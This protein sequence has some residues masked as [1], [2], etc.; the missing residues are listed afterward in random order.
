[1]RLLHT[2]NMDGAGRAET[3]RGTWKVETTYNT[4]R[5]IKRGNLEKSVSALP[6]GLWAKLPTV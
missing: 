1:M 4:E 5:N 2:T 6:K 3:K